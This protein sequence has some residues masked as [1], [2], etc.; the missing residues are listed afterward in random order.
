MSLQ[1]PGRRTL[2]KGEAFS[3]G[4]DPAQAYLFDEAGQAI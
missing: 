3:I 2:G 1:A 4:F